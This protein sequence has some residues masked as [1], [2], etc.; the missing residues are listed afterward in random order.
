MIVKFKKGQIVPKWLQLVDINRKHR[1]L[2]TFGAD[3]EF[4]TKTRIMY[5]NCIRENESYLNINGKNRYNVVVNSVKIHSDFQK[6]VEFGA[7]FASGVMHTSYDAA[8][9]HAP[10]AS[11]ISS[12]LI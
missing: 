4:D 7:L 9:E 3:V 2:I 11:R 6:N 10:F 1:Y 8:Q 5:S 12:I